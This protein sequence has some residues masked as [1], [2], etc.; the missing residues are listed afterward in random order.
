MTAI[1]SVCTRKGGAGKTTISAHLAVAARA[2]GRQV[3]LID[4]DPQFS[5]TGWW[6]R[7]PTK[8]MDC[9]EA[10]P[11][12]LAE[13]MERISNSGDYDLIVIDTPPQ[14]VTAA[15]T[16]MRAS[17]LVVIPLRPSALDLD[18]VAVI[19]AMAKL[20]AK[21]S[22]FVL[23]GVPPRSA[24]TARARGTLETDFATIPIFPGSLGQRSA[25]VEAMATGR[26]V[27]EF[28]P[29]SKAA[30]EVSALWDAVAAEIGG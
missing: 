26:G 29:K 22:L 9:F 6:K 7:R 28:Q 12:D 18:A 13:Q 1:V 11:G 21:K 4:L 23:N 16:A 17:N 10:A 24:Y 15:R 14:S 8:D 5:V 19:A 27:G 25:F 3:A 30:A 20:E 2:V